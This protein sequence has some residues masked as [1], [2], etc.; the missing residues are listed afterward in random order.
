VGADIRLTLQL[1]R[2]NSTVSGT[3]QYL[4]TGKTTWLLGTADSLDNLVIKE[5]YPEDQITGIFKGR[6]S[7]G[8]QVITGFFS[9]PDG[10]RLEPFE[11]REIGTA[12]RH[13]VDGSDPQQ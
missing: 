13:D 8:C 10:S 12:A 11:F 3:E 9:K 2:N 4:R 5:R 7:Q 1:T 6:F